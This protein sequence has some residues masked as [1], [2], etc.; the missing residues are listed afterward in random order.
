MFLCKLLFH[1]I[2]VG[3]LSTFFLGGLN[4][5]GREWLLEY[6][7]GFSRLCD[8][9]HNSF[10]NFFICTNPVGAFQPEMNIKMLQ[11]VDLHTSQ[12]SA[13]GLDRLSQ[14]HSHIISQ[15]RGT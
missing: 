14:K 10:F 5:S 4:D 13:V 9:L 1:V 6:L 3:L 15:G 8:V 12:L 2:T 7:F 11:C